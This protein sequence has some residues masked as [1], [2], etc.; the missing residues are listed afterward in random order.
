MATSS[1]KE[2]WK[3][4]D[5]FR[6]ELDI[7]VSDEALI[8]LIFITRHEGITENEITDRLRKYCSDIKATI[9]TLQENGFISLSQNGQL[10]PSQKALGIIKIIELSKYDI[11]ELPLDAI[12]GYRLI[13]PIG[14]GSSCITFKASEEKTDYDVV[15]K[16]FK[17]GI[18]DNVDIGKAVKSLKPLVQEE[19]SLVIP[20]NYGEFQ[21]NDRTLKY[22]QMDY[23]KG[24]SLGEFLLQNNNI[25]LQETLMNY[26]KEVGSTLLI[27]QDNKFTHGDLHENNI[28]IVKEKSLEDTNVFHFKIIDFIGIN[29]I[30]ELREYELND[31]EYFKQN[32]IKIVNKYALTPSSEVDRKKLGERL[33][34]VYESLLQNKYTSFA[35]ILQ[36]LSE[37]LPER[38]QIRFQRPFTYLIFETYDVNDPLWLR[39]FELESSI[40]H[41]FTDFRPLICSGPRGCGKTIYLRSLSFI[42][43]VIKVCESDNELRKKIAYF[44][45]IFGIYF[46]CRQGEFKVFSDKLFEFTQQT[47]L[48]LK[49]VLMLKIARRTVSLLEEAYAEKVFTSE[50]KIGHVIDFLSPYLSSIPL[51]T[52][53][54]KQRPFKELTTILRNEENNC[55]DSIGKTEKYAKISNLLNEKNLIGFFEAIRN[56][57]AELSDFKFYII[58][59]DLSDPQVY[60]EMQKILNCLMA[61]H[62]GVYCSKFST[63]KYAYTFQDMFGK[64]MQVP[65]DYTYLDLSIVKDY[66]KYLQ[67]II[68]RQLQLGGYEKTIKEYLGNN[69]QSSRQLIYLL[70]KGKHNDVRFAGWNLIGHLSSYSIRDALVICEAIWEQYGPEAEHDKLK[71]G[72]DTISI[73]IQDRALRKYSQEV[74]AALINIESSGNEIFNIVRNFGELSRQYLRRSITRDKNRLYEVIAIERRDNDKLSDEASDLL[75]KLIRHSVFLERG[76]S[77]SREQIGLVQKFVLHKKYTPALKTTFREREH[78]RLDSKQLEQFLL[79]P[80]QFTAQILDKIDKEIATEKYQSKL[81]DFT[82][83]ELNERT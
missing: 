54:S 62:N 2:I 51:M 56:A 26:I 18:M 57:I 44:K 14:R 70:S 69:T 46:A 64:A 5:K 23:I 78:L 8:V 13:K 12:Q 45:N 28:L 31:L 48:F 25:D 55:L 15:L 11:T 40:Y 80:D 72:N 41:Y 6:D 1:I 81:I 68:N 74:Y 58:F 4:V 82:G 73:Y 32:F 39:R 53:S 16:I 22:V 71:Q 19:T 17:P 50:P 3:L 10:I 77:F 9:N 37:K 30:Q 67:R 24:M 66:D 61:C 20:R 65:H 33:F 42:P 76:F 35:D 83:K 34:F 60:P 29:S 49:H 21:W 47:Q 63:D 38:Q 36:S 52:I 59:D 27:L 75:R 7:L 79:S 43:K